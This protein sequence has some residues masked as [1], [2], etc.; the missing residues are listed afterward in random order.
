VVSKP[1]P[2]SVTMIALVPWCEFTGYA[3]TVWIPNETAYAVECEVLQEPSHEL[4]RSPP[5]LFPILNGAAAASEA[6]AEG[7]GILPEPP[8]QRAD[9]RRAHN[10]GPRW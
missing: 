8:A 1:A 6:C 4:V 9:A 2:P 3:I 7:R 5:P 10:T